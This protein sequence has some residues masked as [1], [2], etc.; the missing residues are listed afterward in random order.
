MPEALLATIL[1]HKE[2]VNLVHKHVFGLPTLLSNKPT[3]RWG[4][5]KSAVNMWQDAT[6]RNY[7]CR[8]VIGT[9][10]NVDETPVDVGN[11]TTIRLSR[12]DRSRCPYIRV[13]AHRQRRR[14]V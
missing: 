14:P 6:R 2:G 5:I 1:V 4:D 10:A 11:C 9:C 7:E 3:L 8:M 12:V 13:N